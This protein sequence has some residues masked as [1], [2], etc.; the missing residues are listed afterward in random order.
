MFEKINIGIIFLLV[1][2]FFI[3]LDNLELFLYIHIG[4]LIYYLIKKIYSTNLD[5]IDLGITFMFIYQYFAIIIYS[6]EKIVRYLEVFSGEPIIRSDEYSYNYIFKIL[7]FC[8]I[9][10]PVLNKKM[11]FIKY[12]I[13]L[14]KG[15]HK[16]VFD[17]LGK[18]SI[19][20]FLLNIIFLIGIV[21]Y[22][23]G[24]YIHFI[25]N[26]G[27][28]FNMI[29]W[30]TILNSSLIVYSF[31]TRNYKEKKI[32]SIILM[33][34]IMLYYKL[35]IRMYLMLILFSMLLNFQLRGYKFKKKHIFI[36]VVGVILVLYGN[37]LRFNGLKAKLDL[38][39]F[40]IVFG[41]FIMPSISG[42]YLVNNMLA[43]KI[44]FYD[45]IFN[46]FLQFLPTSIRPEAILYK[47]YNF[48][49]K[50]NIN[51]WPAGGVAIV[52]QLYFFLGDFYIF[53]TYFLK[54]I[55]I[56]I[57]NKKYS[58]HILA[59]IPMLFM[60]LPRMEIWAVRNSIIMIIFNV[61]ILKIVKEVKIK[62]EKNT[63]INR[64]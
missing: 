23:K 50:N 46:L 7:L 49:L 6:N 39:T 60:I 14:E 12:R 63:N 62:N 24:T 10:L 18:I 11:N 28:L 26:T 47:F 43:Y 21:I 36:L 30:I 53:F 33:I 29:G 45:K 41:E 48:Y 9:L 38:N 19:F 32:Y 64:Y 44:S 17:T 22:T 5:C 20:G 13:Y 54:K 40:F 57:K 31:V 58:I 42:N 3:N 35:R 15:F 2:G 55:F 4:L 8:Y 59:G 27:K 16:R 25:P 52:G 56:K 1:I 61:I 37:I 51:I 34:N